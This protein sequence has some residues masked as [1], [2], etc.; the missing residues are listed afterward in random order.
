MFLSI[1]VCFMIASVLFV[2]AITVLAQ[3]ESESTR[4]M[5]ERI[6]KERF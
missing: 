4:K 2:P 3:K 6:K 1:F 5:I